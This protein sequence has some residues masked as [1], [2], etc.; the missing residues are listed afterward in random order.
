MVRFPKKTTK[1]KTK[2]MDI[3]KVFWGPSLGVTW[4][5]IQRSGHAPTS[6]YPDFFNIY[7]KKGSF[8][9]FFFGLFACLTF[10][11]SASLD[12]SLVSLFSYDKI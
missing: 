2:Q 8:G 3:L 9:I 1:N 6:G 5:W 4:M 7:L 12:S 10:S 11:S